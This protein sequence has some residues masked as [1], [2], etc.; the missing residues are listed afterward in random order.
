[1]TFLEA[2]TGI[3]KDVKLRLVKRI[4][5][6]L[7]AAYQDPNDDYRIFFR[8][9]APADVGQNGGLNDD[10][11]RPVY[12]IEGPPLPDIDA[13]RTLVEHLDSAI[14]DAYRDITDVR[15]IMILINE[16]PLEFAG[17]GGRLTSDDTAI[18]EATVLRESRR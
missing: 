10:P 8:E 9:Y 13:R 1:M 12:F 15:D 3:R 16:Y 18:V 4:T 2:P 17:S 6:A 11:V 14:A 5:A 7:E